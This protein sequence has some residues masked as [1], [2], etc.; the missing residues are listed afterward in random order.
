MMR[1][2]WVRVDNWKVWRHSVERFCRYRFRK[3]INCQTPKEDECCLGLGLLAAGISTSFRI[4]RRVLFLP[5]SVVSTEHCTDWCGQMNR[6]CWRRENTEWNSTRKTED[7]FGSPSLLE[8]FSVWLIH[9]HFCG[10]LSVW[11]C[12]RLSKQASPTHRRL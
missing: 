6:M 11:F 9:H 4:C 12:K 5:L 7:A 1:L 2:F 8:W 3:R 10:L